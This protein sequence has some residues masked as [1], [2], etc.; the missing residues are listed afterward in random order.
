MD[1]AGD[2][3][4]AK[5]HTQGGPRRRPA[6]ARA[7]QGRRIIVFFFQPSADPSSKK[8]SPSTPQANCFPL[9]PPHPVVLPTRVT[10]H[11]RLQGF[12]PQE[13]VAMGTPVTMGSSVPIPV[14]TSTGGLPWGEKI[15]FF[16]KTLNHIEACAGVEQG[17]FVS[18]GEDLCFAFFQKGV[19]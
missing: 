10:Q 15:R 4:K 1:A 2:V 13:P 14:R 12:L 6:L 9:K 17:F 16:K 5:L 7:R 19:L 8:S 3:L 18:F 11:R